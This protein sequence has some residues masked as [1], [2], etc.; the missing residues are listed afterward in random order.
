MLDSY[1]AN[2]TS[3]AG[4]LT[5]VGILITYI[6]WD[7]GVRAQGIDR[8][9]FPYRSFLV[10][11]LVSSLAPRADT[12]MRSAHGVL[13]MRSS[14]AASSSSCQCSPSSRCTHG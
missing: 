11:R 8:T 14:C 13:G 6:R 4:L 5:W 2:M 7:R 1:F 10:R 12:T 9:I 3:V